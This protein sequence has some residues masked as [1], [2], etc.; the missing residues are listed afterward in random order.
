M[1]DECRQ[2]HLRRFSLNTA[3]IKKQCSFVSSITACVE[4]GFS[5]IAPWRDQ[6][7]ETSLEKSVKLVKDSGLSV[8][9]LCRG[10]MFTA[11]DSGLTPAAINRVM[12]DNYRAVDEAVA[13]AADS[14]ILV[15]G[16][17]FPESRDLN[18]SRD[19]VED[20]LGQLLEYSKGHMPL[21]IE[22]LHPMY[23]ADRACVNTMKQANDLC[24]SLGEGVGIVVDVYHVW[25][26]PDL[27]NQIKRA[28]GRIVG[29]HVSDWLVPTED[30][31]LD[32]GMMGDGVIDI[33]SIKRS[34][35]RSGYTGPI[36]VEIFSKK[37]WAKNPNE[38]LRTSKDRFIEYC[39]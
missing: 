28:S 19:F 33:R 32:R 36:E 14:L 3:T 4:H 26:D 12:D 27:L 30:L 38:L 24:D 5:Y 35:D 11:L 10:G 16:G 39:Q 29:L 23:A 18:K 13:L 34:V 31:L 8:S 25:W 15:V 20:C 22:P 1:I 17:L 37:W 6:L 2:S 9:S 7:Y 21:G